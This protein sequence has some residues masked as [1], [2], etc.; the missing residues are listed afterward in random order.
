MF[1]K[2][3]SY[4]KEAYITPPPPAA[5]AGVT[6]AVGGAPG[7][8]GGENYDLEGFS[9]ISPSTRDQFRCFQAHTYESPKT[10][11]Q[12]PLSTAEVAGGKKESMFDE[13]GDDVD[14]WDLGLD[15]DPQA[16][17][18]PAREYLPD[19]PT[20]AAAVSYPNTNP[21]TAP[22][23]SEPKPGSVLS[24]WTDAKIEAAMQ[25]IEQEERRQRDLE[26]EVE[27]EIRRRSPRRPWCCTIRR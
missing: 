19:T 13:E 21:A 25:R 3:A 17:R 11:G 14:N 2:G 7:D 22:P 20:P 6:A 1:H 27:E 16:M 23:G 10:P 9:L 18:S 12:D 8:A 15:A 24:P 4:L 5:G 26:L